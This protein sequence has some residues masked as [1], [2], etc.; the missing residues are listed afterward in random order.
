MDKDI[1]KSLLYEYWYY[2]VIAV[3]C[4]LLLK[5]CTGGKELRLANDELKTEVK[6]LILSSDKYVAKNNELSSKILQL[7][8]LKAKV[9]TEIV[10]IENKTKSDLKKVPTLNTKQIGNY[11]QERYKLPV[12]LTQY[13][14]SLSDTLA[15]KNI[16]E[17]IEKD[18]CFAEVKL[19]KVQLQLE[20]KKGIVKDT[21]IGNFKRANVDLNKAIF[22][23]KKIIINTENSLKK[24]KNKKTFWQVT[25]GA[26]LI[27]AGYLLIK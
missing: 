26:I 16:T 17:L 4:F 9:K 21:I 7:E 14:V 18:G 24:E 1:L 8:K 13:G 12:T 6:E 20:E 2:L 10:Y 15:K 3:L 25:S 22:A 11:Y 5:S 23:E 27:G 19:F